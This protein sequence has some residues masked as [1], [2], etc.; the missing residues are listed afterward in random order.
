M[1][2]ERRWAIW[3]AGVVAAGAVAVFVG[4]VLSSSPTTET[5]SAGGQP[6][7]SGVR[8]AGPSSASISIARQ[9]PK[10]PPTDESTS[11]TSA[12]Q[13]WGPTQTM[14]DGRPTLTTPSTPMAETSATPATTA[15]TQG[16]N[17]GPLTDPTAVGPTQTISLTLSRAEI[18]AGESATV[19][20]GSSAYLPVFISAGPPDICMLDTETVR[21]LRAGRCTIVAESPGNDEFEPASRS[22]TVDVVGK[23]PAF[24]TITAPGFLS[25]GTSG[26]VSA[27]S[28][29]SDAQITITASGDCELHGNEVI[30]LAEGYC[31]ITAS[32]PE[33]HD[34]LAGTAQVGIALQ[35]TRPPLPT[36]P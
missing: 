27:T 35:D 22:L 4:I 8:P 1:D 29:A 7:A 5:V 33:T 34:A 20:A 10:V 12:E 36:R 11:G 19:H 3:I 2:G 28:T 9:S 26:T 16:N 25:V 23:A 6:G 15:T 30:P 31:T 32:H 17:S 13:V 18:P 14:A 21:G 24:I